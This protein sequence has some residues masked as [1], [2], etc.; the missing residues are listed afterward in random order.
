MGSTRRSRIGLALGVLLAWASAAGWTGAPMGSIGSGGSVAWAQVPARR[1]NP[2]DTRAATLPAELRDWPASPVRWLLQERELQAF[3]ALTNSESAMEFIREFWH[4]RDPTPRDAEN[5]FAD[6][7]TERVK[8]AD[9]LFTDELSRGALTDR[10]GALILLGSPTSIRVLRRQT[11]NL[12]NS[13]ARGSGRP[14]EAP[15]PTL[16]VEVERWRFHG[17][18]ARGARD[19]GPSGGDRAR[20]RPPGTP[21][22]L[23]LGPRLAGACRQ[24]SPE[25]R[26]TR[27]SPPPGSD[28]LRLTPLWR[29]RI[30]TVRRIEI[31][32][33]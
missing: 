25:R 17:R 21:G 7:F 14:E 15:V 19:G 6:E 1:P 9:A 28:W 16:G 27:G 18:R 2:A 33:A 29:P 24:G 22:A 23:R 12:R 3:R 13:A 26:V 8:M 30:A 11:P 31:V 4:R 10:G 5:P 32:G 20:I